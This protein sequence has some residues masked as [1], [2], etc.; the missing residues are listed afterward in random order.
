MQEREKENRATA[1]YTQQLKNEAD[2]VT[3]SLF[4]NFKNAIPKAFDFK[5]YDLT[6]ESIEDQEF[7]ILDNIQ[8]DKTNAVNENKKKQKKKAKN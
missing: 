3:G 7:N 5:N 6:E 1:S 2:G 8:N 4:D